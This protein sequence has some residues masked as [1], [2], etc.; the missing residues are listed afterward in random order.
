MT[1]VVLLSLVTALVLASIKSKQAQSGK[2]IP[3]RVRRQ[4]N[5]HRR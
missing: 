2:L 5:N 1:T 4:P 3:V